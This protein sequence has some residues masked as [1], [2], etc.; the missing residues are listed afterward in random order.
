MIP[1]ILA[2]LA[3]GLAAG[4]VAKLGLDAFQKS[5]CTCAHCNEEMFKSASYTCSECG[6]TLCQKHT[7]V[8]NHPNA[9]LLTKHTDPIACAKCVEAAFVKVHTRIAEVATPCHCCE[10]WTLKQHLV[11]CPEC[12]E[13]SC[14][15]C[16]EYSDTVTCSDTRHKKTETIVKSQRVC[17]KCLPTVNAV[18]AERQKAFDIAQTKVKFW[19]NSKQGYLPTL[20]LNVEICSDVMDASAPKLAVLCQA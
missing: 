9:R 5:R 19:P 3:G 16:M 12:G 6:D 18:I 8:V 20:K 15:S 10:S 1:I 4:T 14:S 11:A 2:G 13:L 17:T 7:I